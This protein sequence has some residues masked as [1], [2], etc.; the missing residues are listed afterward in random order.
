M[1]NDEIGGRGDFLGSRGF[2]TQEE[3]DGGEQ[4][5]TNDK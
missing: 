5:I 4:P 2:L 1:M 3:L